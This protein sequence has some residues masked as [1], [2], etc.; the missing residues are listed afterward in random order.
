MQK[1]NGKDDVWSQLYVEDKTVYT[2]YMSS[3]TIVTSTSSLQ[4]M[5]GSAGRNDFTG[6]A[7]SD[8]SCMRIGPISTSAEQQFHTTAS[9]EPWYGDSYSRIKQD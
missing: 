9:P 1:W 7:V 2:Q 8:S 5:P 4:R 3:G 6:Q